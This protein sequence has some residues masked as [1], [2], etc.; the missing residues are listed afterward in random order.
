MKSKKQLILSALAASIV[1][2][3]AW[4][5]LVWTSQSTSIANANAQR[6]KS[7]ASAK[8]LKLRIN[9]LEAGK[10]AQIDQ[11]GLLAKINAAIPADPQL[12]DYMHNILKVAKDNSVTL[13]ASQHA[14][15][16]ANGAVAAPVPATT[17]T[18]VAAKSGAKAASSG[19][20]PAPQAAAPVA[21]P[22]VSTGITLT[23]DG[24]YEHIL[25][26]VHALDTQAR[27][28]VV[29]S[30][31]LTAGGATASID[32]G[33]TPSTSVP[34]SDSPLTASIA[35]HILSTGAVAATTNQGGTA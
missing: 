24:T 14:Q 2:V 21:G 35:A 34:A 1:I 16:T 6:T 5:Q 33:S 18:T 28:I 27:L 11:L 4:Y 12:A 19:A 8:S 25:A 22:F 29:D 10:Q 9:Q 30:V 20:T 13:T 32:G 3:F 31:S 23:V 15:A 26:F 7:A 17:A